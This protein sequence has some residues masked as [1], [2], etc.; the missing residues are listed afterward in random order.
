MGSLRLCNNDPL[1]KTLRDVFG[2]NIIRVP[3]ERYKPL[4][5]LAAHNNHASFRGKLSPLLLD[6]FTF[7]ESILAESQMPDLSGK[8]SQSVN[9]KLGLK[10][11]DGYLKGLGIP[12]ASLDSSFNGASEVSYTFQNVRRSWIDINAVGH[13]LSGKKI[14]SKNPAA[15][16]F[17]GEDA[18]PFLL[19][20]SVI[21]S[22]DFTISVDRTASSNFSFDLPIIKN[23][24]E[25]ANVEVNVS[26]TSGYDLTFQG[27]KQL[28]FAFSCVRLTIEKDGTI[29]GILPT[30]S[31][32]VVNYM[33]L[34]T[35][36]L[37]DDKELPV[38]YSPDR[39][40]LNADPAM[41]EFD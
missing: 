11:L 41:V 21:T 38:L 19:L 33:R 18:Y 8:R 13:L 39:V 32:L 9:V 3:E 28:A 7:P 26:T 16:I 24:I 14:D 34:S 40:L 22:S 12:G 15:S 25:N 27:N 35:D 20:D 37:S 1:I 17:F 2:T 10:I 6:N 31:D 29:G 23:V 4:T 36:L 5:V 30:G